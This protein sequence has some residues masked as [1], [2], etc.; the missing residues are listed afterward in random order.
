MAGMN[1]YTIQSSRL[2]R[3]Y[4]AGVHLLALAAVLSAA[5]SW[6]IQ[7]GLAAVVLVSCVKAWP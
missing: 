5:L 4:F 6:Q 2:L 1:V 7:L 3:I